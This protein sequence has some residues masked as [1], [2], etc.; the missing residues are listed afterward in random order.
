MTPVTSSRCQ[1]SK[2]SY[3]K[4]IMMVKKSNVI[5]SCLDLLSYSWIDLKSQISAPLVYQFTTPTDLGE[6][7]FHWF[8]E[9]P[10][11][12]DESVTC[13]MMKRDTVFSGY[14]A[15]PCS[16]RFNYICEFEGKFNNQVCLRIIVFDILF[17][18]NCHWPENI[19][20]N[21][22]CWRDNGGLQH[23]YYELPATY[24]GKSPIEARTACPAGSHLVTI[25][26]EDEAVFLFAL[27]C[28][29]D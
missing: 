21:T 7:Y 8:D 23:C 17:S 22:N 20:S 11:T 3:S 2:Y 1:P 5:F 27:K 25:T 18:N 15:K 26:S 13:V 19:D 12:D 9:S 28:K 14:I 24:A 16:D 10:P 29:Y 4:Q 6:P